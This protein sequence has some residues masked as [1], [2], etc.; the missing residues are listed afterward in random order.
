MCACVKLFAGK[1]TVTEG[2]LPL[3]TDSE[4]DVEVKE[5]LG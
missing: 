2:F 4:Y 3:M 5:D 1:R